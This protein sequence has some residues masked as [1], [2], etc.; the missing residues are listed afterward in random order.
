MKGF[1]ALLAGEAEGTPPRQE[2]P[3]FEAFCQGLLGLEN[4]LPT[5]G[6]STKPLKVKL[7]AGEQKATEILSRDPNLFRKPSDAQTKRIRFLTRR[8]VEKNGKGIK[9]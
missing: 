5:Y 4:F 1:E 6:F 3:S 7:L 9:A 2:I 8:M